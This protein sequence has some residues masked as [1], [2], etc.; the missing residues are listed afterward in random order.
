[1]TVSVSPQIYE[2]LERLSET[3]IAGRSPAA[4]A[5]MMITDHIKALIG[6]DCLRDHIKDIFKRKEQ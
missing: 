5:E 1:M 4:V 2:A 3:G 6:E